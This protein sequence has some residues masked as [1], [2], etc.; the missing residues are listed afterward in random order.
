MAQAAAGAHGAENGESDKRFWVLA[1]GSLGVVYGDIGTSPLYAL[2][3]AVTAATKHGASANTEAVLGIL[4]LIVWTMFLIVTVKYVLVLLNADNKGEGGTFALM[5]LGQSVA[6]RSSS[7]ILVLGV[8]GASFFYGDAVITPAISVLSAVEGLKLVAPQMES[9]VLPLT[10]AILVALFAVQSRGTEKVARFFGPLTLIWFLALAIGGLI[11]IVDDVR[12][13]QALNPLLGMQFIM[14]H[15]VIGL[16]VMGLI[17]LVVTGAEALYA[18]LGHFGRR[19]IQV[20]WLWIVQPA[21]I[22]NYF[23]QGALLL[24]EPE[25]IENPFYRLYPS[26]ALIPMVV[27]ATVATVIASQ[28]VITG[29]FSFTRQAIQLGLLPRLAIR[30]TSESVAGQIFLPRVNQLL[31]VGVLLVTL[32]FRSSSDLAAAYGLSVTATMVIDSLMAFFVVWRCWGWPV[33]RVSMLIVPLLMI[34]QAFLTAN[35]LKI[36]EGGWLPLLV[37]GMIILA[38][39]TWVRGSASLARATRKSEAELDWLVRKLDAKPPHRV[40]GTAVF[41]TGDPTAAPT[42]LMHNL[43]HNRVL[44]ERN[45]IL[46]IK[47]EDTPRVQRHE[48]IEIERVADTF[49]RVIAH[50][51]FMETPSVPKI[52]EH[53]RRKDLNIDISATSFFL[54]RRSL[55]TTIKS[56]MPRWQE[57]LFIWLAGRAEDATEYFRIPSDRVVEVGTQ[58]MV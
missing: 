1:L 50:Y 43:K 55:K 5:A 57:R 26:W 44:H 28:A 56:E 40:P 18:D 15:G 41:L 34:E 25:A 8:V 31:F 23:G 39:L 36:P 45:I 37:A 10:I 4:S 19:P 53:C 21:L 46:T 3:E 54:S 35:I 48:R 32:I 33:W 29:A 30:H 24:A 49:I 16:A 22:L 11:H 27:L 52:L 51:G 9:V 20:A 6:Q 7:L 17:F 38:V 2:R 47:T 13:F 14:T 42:S 12:V 58:V